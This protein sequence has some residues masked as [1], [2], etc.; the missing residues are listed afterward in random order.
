MFWHKITH[1]DACMAAVTSRAQTLRA[2]SMPQDT[3]RVPSPLKSYVEQA[4]S[5]PQRA[6]GLHTHHAQHLVLVAQLAAKYCNACT[7]GGVPEPHGVICSNA[8]TQRNWFN[9]VHAFASR[10][11]HVADARVVLELIDSLAMPNKR[12]YGYEIRA[13]G[14]CVG[15]PSPSWMWTACNHKDV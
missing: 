2:W 5:Y 12:L 1:V 7:C 6:A 11:Q 15:E 4:L 13:C 14:R 9:D 10:E 8:V 3:M